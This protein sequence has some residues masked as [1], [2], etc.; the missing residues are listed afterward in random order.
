M[1]GGLKLGTRSAGKGRLITSQGDAIWIPPRITRRY[2]IFY[3]PPG[4]STAASGRDPIFEP[5]AHIFFRAL[6]AGG[7]VVV[8]TDW[9]IG[10]PGFYTS[11]WGAPQIVVNIETART[12]LAAAIH[13]AG[14]DV[15]ILDT[16]ELVFAG[17]SQGACDIFSYGQAH[18]DKT[19]A[20]GTWAGALDLL[21]YYD[22]VARWTSDVAAQV[23]PAVRAC[24]A[25]NRAAAA[26][27]DPYNHAAAFTAPWMLAY[28]AGD[29]SASP[30]MTAALASVLPD[31]DTVRVSLTTPHADAIAGD[32]TRAGLPA[33]L[34]DKAT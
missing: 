1:L 17:G 10:T 32:A 22:G 14:A 5:G 15:G 3:L 11:S 21:G 20:A 8:I 18:P 28:S 27:A 24:W 2:P 6:A 12:G 7:A 9:D 29:A 25:N 26:A 34:L 4:V 13:A 16:S 31:V 30:E 33:W 23:Q 19:R